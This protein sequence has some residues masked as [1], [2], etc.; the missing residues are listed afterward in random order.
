MTKRR[1]LYISGPYRADTVNGIHNN[2]AEARKRAE[3]GWANGYFPICPHLNSAFIDG[4]VPDKDILEC[5]LQLVDLC[6]VILMVDG[7]KDS[8]GS[9]AELQRAKKSRLQVISDPLTKPPKDMDFTEYIKQVI[10]K[11]IPGL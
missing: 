8:Q 2:I 4:L 9:I 5:Y 3:W 11:D 1:R 6:H 10:N 7:W